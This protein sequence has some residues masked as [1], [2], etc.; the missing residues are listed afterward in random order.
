MNSVSPWLSN[1]RVIAFATIVTGAS[2]TGC[3]GE[4]SD[5][6]KGHPPGDDSFA[7]LAPPPRHLDQITSRMSIVVRGRY[8]EVVEVRRDPRP[9]PT[10]QV[11]TLGTA[12]EEGSPYSLMRFEVSEYIVGEGSMELTVAQ[13]GD[14][15]DSKGHRFA[16]AEPVFGQEITLIAY[17]WPGR[18]SIVVSLGADYGR[19]VEK[20][21]R[22]AYAFL[23]E[24]KKG[25]PEF[26]ALPFAQGMNLEQF[27]EALR[28]AA[29]E[30]GLVVPE[31]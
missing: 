18:P 22:I 16:V 29:R 25:R 13:S 27:H 28:E 17:P 5:D 4:S 6:A 24:E 21:G 30:R 31:G 11:E 15:T 3:V 20:D 14:L 19:F 12:T 8:T 2:L 26:E 9:V 7:V 10:E 1:V 23:S